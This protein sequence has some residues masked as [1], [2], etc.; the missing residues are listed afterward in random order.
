MDFL[1]QRISM[2]LRNS[3]FPHE[4]IQVKGGYILQFIEPDEDL[5]KLISSLFITIDTGEEDATT[6]MAKYKPVNIF[7][8]SGDAIVIEYKHAAEILNTIQPVIRDYAIKKFNKEIR[9]Y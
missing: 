5:K 2:W 8:S 7:T 1:I 6:K 4:L 3:G 9:G